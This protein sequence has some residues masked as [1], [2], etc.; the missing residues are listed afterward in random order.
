MTDYNALMNMLR[1]G[2]DTQPQ[3]VAWNPFARRTAVDP[4]LGTEGAGGPRQGGGGART[5][6]APK[7]RD[8]N[9]DE[10]AKVHADVLAKAKASGRKYLT[11]TEEMQLFG[12]EARLKQFGRWPY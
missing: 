2:S 6:P 9:L 3:E 12:I 11:P 10:L 1:V 4:L 8:Y 7:M 5:V